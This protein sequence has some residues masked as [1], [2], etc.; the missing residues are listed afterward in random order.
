MSDSLQP[1]GI[2]SPWNSPSQNT[3]VGSLSLLQGIFP[4]Q[5]SNPGLPHCRQILYQLSP[6]GSPRVLEWVAYPF[7]SGS[8]RPRNWTRVSCIASRFFTNWA[9]REALTISRSFL[10]F[11]SIE[12]IMP[13]NHLILC[14]PLLL[15]PSIFPSITVFSNEL[16][17]HIR[18]P[19][20]WSLTS[21]ILPMNIQGW[22]PLGLTGLIS[23]QSKGLSN[24]TV[25]KHQFFGAQPSLWSSSHIH[26]WLLAKP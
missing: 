1:H 20:Y 21:S 12:L 25:W 5:G 22:Y 26:T 13:S 10:E 2:Y 11:M 18:W 9:I 3:T 24:T 23:F 15:L 14:C 8:S 4:T 7:C 16:A 6:K 19:M 17:L